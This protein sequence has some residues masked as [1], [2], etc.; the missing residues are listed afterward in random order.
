MGQQLGGPNLGVED[1]VVLAHEV[2]G[3]CLGIVPP[4][5][6]V[7][8]A[9]SARRFAAAC[10]LHRGGQV[11]DNGIEPHVEALV[12]LVQPARDRNAPGDVAAHGARANIVKKVLGEGDDVGTPF[13]GGLD[14]VQ[15]H[16]ERIGERGQIEEVVLGDLELRRLARNLRH[17]VDKLL[18]VKLI[19]AIVALIPAGAFRAADRT[20][21][22]NVAVGKSVPRN[23]IDSH[24]GVL[25]NHVTVI[26]AHLEHLLHNP[27]MIDRGGAGKQIVGQ[28]ESH[29]VLDN[30]AVVLVR[31]CLGG[32]ALF[33]SRH[34]NRGAMLIGTGDH[35][36]VL[37]THSHVAGENIG[38]DTKAGNVA[39][40]TGTV[41]IR[42]G[43]C[44][45]NM[46][47]GYKTTSPR[48][49]GHIRMESRAGWGGH[50]AGWGGLWA[51]FGVRRPMLR[52]RHVASILR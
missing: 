45:E 11:A 34:Q 4:G 48:G 9:A 14:F 40:V 36:D 13:A 5:T 16:A 43:N 12:R 33:L 52:P 15:P 47:H 39:D 2:V 38:G 35:E 20:G 17:R 28:A 27:L 8:G 21:A 51:E 19:A 32:H 31:E 23:R 29:E 22:L 24:G 42:P 18:G 37:A 44:G 30:N 26:A 10:P 6:P 25:H 7:V 41:G 50:W 3:Q 46:R 49:A 1:D